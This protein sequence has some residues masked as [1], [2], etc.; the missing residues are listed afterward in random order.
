MASKLVTD[1]EKLTRA[2]IAAATTHRDDIAAGVAATLSPYLGKGERLPDVALLMDLIARW[3]NTAIERL[4]DADRAHELEL[5][6]DAQPRM[7]R[8]EAAE[9]LRQ[10]LIDLRGAVEPLYGTSGLKKLAI[11]GPVPTDPSVVATFTENVMVALGDTSIEL[12]TPR[13]R[14]ITIDRAGFAAELGELL[15]RLRTALADVAREAREAE[16]TQS[17]KNAAMLESDRATSRGSSWLLVTAV[18]GGRED[19]GVRLR[20]PQP[21][22]GASAESETSEAKSA[23]SAEVV[24]EGGTKPP[25]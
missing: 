5:G 19:L 22:R 12:G 9:Q 2:L 18:L 23:A 1:R 24:S 15:P 25:A 6:D 17:A 7:D 8:D 21:R 20:P 11:D 13:R 3:Q 10:V 16:T 14:G 4:L